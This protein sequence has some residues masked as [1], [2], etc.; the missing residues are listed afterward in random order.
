MNRRR[1]GLAAFLSAALAVPASAG[2]ERQQAA[3]GQYTVDVGKLPLNLER[4]QRQL[5]QSTVREDHD[6]LNLRYMVDVFGQAPKIELFTPDQN[7]Q[8]GPVPYGAPTHREMLQMMT[9]QEHRA[10]AADFG[11]LFRWLAD[12]AK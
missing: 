6:G 7:L 12:K 10:P 11:S 3:G 9:P 1:I 2:Q 8:T 5:R 4:V